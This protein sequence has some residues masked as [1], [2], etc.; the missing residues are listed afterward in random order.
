MPYCSFD[1]GF[2]GRDHGNNDGTPPDSR[3]VTCVGVY[4]FGGRADA[5]N[6]PAT[7]TVTKQGQ[8][9]N[10]A[11]IEPIWMSSYTSFVKAEIANKLG[12]N[13]EALTFLVAGVTASIDRVQAFGKAKGQE[14]PAA[15]VTPK[16]DY[17]D[18]VVSK[19]NLSSD[20][21][22]NI[23]TEYYI[24]LW[25]NGVEAYNMYRRTGKPNSMQLM[26]AASPGPFQ[27]SLI[28]PSDYVNLNSNAT[29]KSFT[30]V[31]RVFWDTNTDPNFCK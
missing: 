4:P 24:A 30:G 25:G 13:D 31:N 17:I 8:G 26:R 3:A 10:G 5:I 23:M 18:V 27:Y 9:A 1:P 19:Y 20:K 12:Q 22:N 2:Y 7:E 29:Q 28:Y 21:L 16:Q 11:G 6:S 14:P 15:L